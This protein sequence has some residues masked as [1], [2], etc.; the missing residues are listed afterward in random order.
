M[1][2]EYRHIIDYENE[3][4]EMRRQGK[5]RKEICEKYGFTLRQ[6]KDFITR[7]NQKRKNLLQ[8]SQLSL[9]A[10]QGKMDPN[11]RHPYNN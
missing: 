1:P 11:Y 9:K 5:T 3:I 2:R 6:V 8:E 7:Y 10:D 4:L